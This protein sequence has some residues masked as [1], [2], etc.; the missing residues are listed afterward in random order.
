[1]EYLY[2]SG[3]VYAVLRTASA[4]KEDIVVMHRGVVVKIIISA[5][6]AHTDAYRLFLGSCYVH[7]KH[8]I[9]L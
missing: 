9:G 6:N 2:I 3:K 5:V 1:M 8:L 7:N 4:V